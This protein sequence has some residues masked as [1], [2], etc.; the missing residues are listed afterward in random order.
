MKKEDSDFE[1]KRKNPTSKEYQK[2]RNEFEK[3][4]KKLFND[5]V[6]Y[7][8]E[9]YR[10]AKAILWFVLEPKIARGISPFFHSSSK[11]KQDKDA[12]AEYTSD[13]SRLTATRENG[14]FRFLN[15]H[16]TKTSYGP[17]MIRQRLSC[18]IPIRF[19]SQRTIF[20]RSKHDSIEIKQVLFVFKKE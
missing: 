8:I 10:G 16:L 18:S 15:V 17:R 3:R 20:R 12:T 4:K 13:R 5:K 11:T 1:E 14:G 2:E 9:A 7:V 19:A 6:Y